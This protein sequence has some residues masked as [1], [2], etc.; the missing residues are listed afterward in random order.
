MLTLP[1]E[2]TSSKIEVFYYILGCI[3]M[4]S[5]PIRWMWKWLKRVDKAATNDIPHIYAILKLMCD[6]MGIEYL[7]LKVDDEKE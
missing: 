6:H 7:D 2:P 3:A 4:I 5:W 1:A